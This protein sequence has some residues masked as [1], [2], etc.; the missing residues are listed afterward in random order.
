MDMKK[1]AIIIFTLIV[2]GCATFGRPATRMN[3]VSVGMT[4]EQVI[5][6]VGEPVSVSANAGAEFL[7]YSFYECVGCVYVPYF[8][9]LQNG[10]VESYGRLGDF[11]STKSPEQNINLNVKSGD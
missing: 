11:N 3:S 5:K 6:K 4:K 1:T 2:S 7:N 8:I 10:K 9:K